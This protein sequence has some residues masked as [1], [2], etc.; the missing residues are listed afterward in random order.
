MADFLPLDEA[1]VSGAVI[2]IVIVSVSKGQADR[3][4]SVWSQLV[5]II[6]DR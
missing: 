1:I 4:K 3:R 6:R 5:K 2:V